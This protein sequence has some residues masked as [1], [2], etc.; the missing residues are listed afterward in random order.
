V[1]LHL[2]GINHF[3]PNC[4]WLLEHRLKE[5]AVERCS[6]PS[7]VA[8]EWDGTKFLHVALLQRGR[9]RSLCQKEWPGIPNDQL[10]AL[11][12]GLGF[13]A[14]THVEIF[15]DAQT[16]W[17]DDGDPRPIAKYAEARLK[18]Y[19]HALAVE[20]YLP[21]AQ[22]TDV[23]AKL[24]HWARDVEVGPIQTDRSRDA[25]FAVAIAK[26]VPAKVTGWAAVIVGWSHTLD[27]AESMAHLLRLLG[28]SIQVTSLKGA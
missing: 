20:K 19:R 22:F 26:Q 6:T 24:S 9:F 18:M 3:N 2:F 8:V 21:N 13:E 15:P 23:Q 5:V 17:L 12:T 14:D 27:E 25:R 7:F 10:D 1:D 28:Y 4:R 11:V 16:V